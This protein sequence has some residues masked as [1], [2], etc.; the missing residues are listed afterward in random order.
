MIITDT[1][2]PQGEEGKLENTGSSFS[3]IK[4]AAA[5]FKQIMYHIQYVWSNSKVYVKYLHALGK[6]RL[7]LSPSKQE[8]GITTVAPTPV[9]L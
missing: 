3:I 6:S 4:Y 7:K 5:T 1:L 9:P 2:N 8:K